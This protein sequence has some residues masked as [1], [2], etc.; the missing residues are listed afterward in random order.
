V[1]AIGRD[2]STSAAGNS[3]FNCAYRSCIFGLSLKVANKL[4]KRNQMREQIDPTNDETE[5]IFQEIAK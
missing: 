3:G 1:V 2:S 4:N 5:N